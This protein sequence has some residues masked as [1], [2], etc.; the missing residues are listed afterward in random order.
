MLELK[1]IMAVEIEL[2][3]SNES[4]KLKLFFLTREYKVL[5]KQY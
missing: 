1:K 5:L 2:V 4:K 3:K